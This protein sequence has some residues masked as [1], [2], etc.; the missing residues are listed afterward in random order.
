[1]KKSKKLLSLFLAALMLMSCF[2]AIS[3][4]AMTMDAAETAAADFNATIPDHSAVYANKSAKQW[5][6]TKTSLDTTLGLV[7]KAV[8]IKNS[9]YTDAT[10]N[11]L[12]TNIVGMLYGMLDD[13]AKALKESSNFGD[14]LAGAAINVVLKKLTPAEVGAAMSKAGVYP[15]IAAYLQTVASYDEIDTAKL[16]WGITAGNREQFAEAASWAISPIPTALDVICGLQPDIYDALAVII[17][18][19]HQ[20]P[21]VSLENFR[22]IV[23]NEGSAAAAGTVITPVCDVIDDVAAAPLEYLCEILPDLTNSFAAGMATLKANGLLGGFLSDLPDGLADIIPMVIPMLPSLLGLGEDYVMPE[24]NLPEIDEH[25]LITMGTA[26]AAESGMKDGARMAIKGNSTMVFAAVAQ[27]VQEVL[28]DKN[29]QAAIGDLVVAKA[30]PEYLESYRNIVAAAQN[31]TALDVADACLSLI[32][33][34]AHNT[35]AQEDV[36][37][38]VAFFAKIAEFFSN[39]AK[40]ILA[41]FK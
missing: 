12:M 33:E 21:M 34:V 4:S 13:A 20:G 23:K 25:Y 31:G 19:L 6:N 7:L 39:L 22:A 24:L 3:A 18:S 26:Y 11:M 41:L 30:G 36:N 9:I 15:E 38:I 40:K 32:E 28:Q 2:G 27:Y 17:E 10:V 1:M 37:P 14:K 35:G 5:N 16:V 29:N 8:N